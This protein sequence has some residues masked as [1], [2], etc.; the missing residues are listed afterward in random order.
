MEKHTH[1]QTP[2]GI[3]IRLPTIFF[4]YALARILCDDEKQ[5]RLHRIQN[6]IFI[7]W[8]VYIHF[9]FLLDSLGLRLCFESDSFISFLLSFTV[10][11]FVIKL[12]EFILILLFFIK[13]LLLLITFNFT[14]I[15][16]HFVHNL[17]SRVITSIHS[18]RLLHRCRY[19]KHTH[20]TQFVMRCASIILIYLLIMWK[21]VR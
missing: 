18:A 16:N 17:S 7:A 2:S 20:K 5:T 9:R 6:S 11:V 3:K 4:Y 10:H 15:P 14:S 19:H 13:G 1:T 8:T 12:N 21:T